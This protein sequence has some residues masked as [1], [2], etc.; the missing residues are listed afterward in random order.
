MAGEKSAVNVALGAAM[1]SA[2]RE[3]GHTQEGFAALA[4]VSSRYYGAVERG[5]FSPSVNVVAKVAA[6]LGMRPSELLGRAG[7]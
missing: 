3:R 7:L 2:R 5:E 4:G 1:R 6:A